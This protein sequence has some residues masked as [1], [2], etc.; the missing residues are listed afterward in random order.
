MRFLF[1]LKVK[2]LCSQTMLFSFFLKAKSYQ[3]LF[4]KHVLYINYVGLTR[5]YLKCSKKVDLANWSRFCRLLGYDHESFEH[6]NQVVIGTGRTITSIK[7]SPHPGNIPYQAGDPHPVRVDIHVYPNPCG[8]ISIPN[9]ILLLV[10][11]WCTGIIG[12]QM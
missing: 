6:V 5:H 11:G 9:Y 1:K 10:K 8:W 4:I 3:K 12:N 7:I 2:S